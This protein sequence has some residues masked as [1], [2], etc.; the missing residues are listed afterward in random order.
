MG[1]YLIENTIFIPNRFV[2]ES[3]P[4][5]IDHDGDKGTRDCFW[6]NALGDCLNRMWGLTEA[7]VGID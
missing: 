2:S 7:H 4:L 1:K 3:S 6:C 5:L